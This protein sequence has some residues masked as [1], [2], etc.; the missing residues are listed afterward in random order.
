[1]FHHEMT[2]QDIL[3]LR[4]I[5]GPGITLLRESITGQLRSGLFPISPAYQV[6]GLVGFKLPV[7]VIHRAVYLFLVPGVV[8]TTSVIKEVD[9]NLLLSLIQMNLVQV[10]IIL[11]Q[12]LLG[13]G[14]GIGLEDILGKRNLIAISLILEIP[15]DGN[16][17]DVLGL[18]HIMTGDLDIVRLET[19]SYHTH[20]ISVTILVGLPI[21]K[22][23]G[24]GFLLSFF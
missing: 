6:P 8:G 2:G 16:T 15:I 13:P 11:Y 21:F 18:V 1:M 4:R 20:V 23:R 24:D 9:P 22:K 14:P 5:P 12:A 17:K 3:V 7:Y 19:G 10:D